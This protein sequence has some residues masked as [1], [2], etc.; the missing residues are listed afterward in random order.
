MIARAWMLEDVEELAAPSAERRAW[1]LADALVE[2]RPETA[3][4][5]Y[6]SLRAQ[7]ERLPGL[8]YWM[9]QRVRAALD[10][11]LALEAGEP[12]AQIKRRLR[13]PSR[14]GDRLIA[15][16]GRAGA[17]R[18]REALATDR[19]PR[20]GLARRG[21]GRGRRGHAGARGDR[22]RSPS[23]RFRAGAC[24][25]P[26]RGACTAPAGRACTTGCLARAPDARR[27]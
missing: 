4:Q 10:V 13:M 9:A 18:L 16:A 27:P 7:G 21:S 12:P 2:G 8:I 5:T 22:R 24:T 26:R 6:L 19:R 15:D 25:R 14:A 20:A 1:A 11:A 17:E 23:R 3:V